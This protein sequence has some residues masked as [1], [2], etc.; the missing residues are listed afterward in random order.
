MTIVILGGMALVLATLERLAHLRFRPARLLRAGFAS[1]TVYLLTGYVA[2]GSLAIAYV[3][4]GSD[5][6]IRL[7]MPRL[8]RTALSPWIVTPLALVALDLGNYVAHWLLHRVDVL[9]EFHKV[10]HSS[11][12][13]D[14][15]ATFRSH[16]VEQ[17]LRRLLAPVVLIAAGVPTDAVVTAAVAFQAWAMLNHA[18]L[19]V[20]LAFLEPVLVTPRLH[21]LH[22]VPRTTERNL[23]TVL[24][25]W[26]RLRGTLVVDDAPVD[27]PLG[28][29]GDQ[30][31]Y[32][33]GWMRQLVE[34]FRRTAAASRTRPQTSTI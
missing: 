5:V 25:C 9:W 1:D 4:A 30:A 7:G 21:R 24:T 18:N 2:G 3:V 19:R 32:P 20:P 33:Q 22:H 28:I 13:L 8:A 6:M 11:P 23:G 10:H 16:L 15:L 12:S 14:W 29:P 26:D 17:A 31:S 27:A 34:P